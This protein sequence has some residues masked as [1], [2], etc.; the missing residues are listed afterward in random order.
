MFLL[1]RLTS[2]MKLR[3]SLTLRANVSGGRPKENPNLAAPLNDGPMHAVVEV[4]GNQTEVGAHDDHQESA[5]VPLVEVGEGRIRGAVQELSHLRP[6]LLHRL[7]RGVDEDVCLFVGEFFL[8]E[9]A[10]K[11]QVLH[12][13]DSKLLGHSRVEWGVMNAIHRV[14]H[15]GGGLPKA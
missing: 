12:P 3:Y 6:A 1:G 4:F 7:E 13:W 15:N 2:F 14:I 5:V 9:P 11:S 8:R 10:K